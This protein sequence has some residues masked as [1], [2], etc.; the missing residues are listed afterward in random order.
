MRARDI[1]A[2]IAKE[3]RVEE[4]STRCRWLPAYVQ[5]HMDD[6]AQHIYMLLLEKPD[7]MMSDLWESG[8]INCY[9]VKMMQTQMMRKSSF[10]QLYGRHEEREIELDVFDGTPIYGDET[11]EGTE[12][13]AGDIP[14]S[15]E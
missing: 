3:R 14:C 8:A 7:D 13:F 2:I 10:Y 5:N 15:A 12:G 1:V 9:I 6:F 4:L 11:E